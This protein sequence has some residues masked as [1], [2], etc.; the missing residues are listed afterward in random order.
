MKTDKDFL[1]IMD[2][3][4]GYEMKYVDADLQDE[5]ISLKRRASGLQNFPLE[6][7]P[8]VADERFQNF[9]DSVSVPDKTNW[10]NRFRPVM[11]IS[12]IAA[13]LALLLIFNPFQNK[14]VLKSYSALKSNPDKLTYVYALNAEK[15]SKKEISELKLLLMNEQN[16]NIKIAILDLL[17]NYTPQYVDPMELFLNL[18]KSSTPSVQMA[19]LNTMEA[20]DITAIRNNLDHFRGTVDLEETVKNKIQEMLNNSESKNLK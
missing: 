9:I 1:K 15:L 11:I 10:T 5:I 18:N 4:D 2:H 3:V 14:E 12:A 16:P 6:E 20:T 13:G 17:E 7:V 8:A 19:M